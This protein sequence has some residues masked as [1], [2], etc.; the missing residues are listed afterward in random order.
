MRAAAQN[1]GHVAKPVS[2]NKKLPGQ[3]D[4]SKALLSIEEQIE[5]HRS[6]VV[7]LREMNASD[8][9]DL[10]SAVS[11]AGYSENVTYFDGDKK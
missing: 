1:K 10:K 3:Y 9:A 4:R 7:D 8:A 6:V 5:N 2:P 11:A